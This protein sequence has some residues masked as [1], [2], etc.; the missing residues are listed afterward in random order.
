MDFISTSGSDKAP[1]GG[2]RLKAL[3]GVAVC[4][5]VWGDLALKCLTWKIFYVLFNWNVSFC[6]CFLLLHY[7]KKHFKAF[8][9][10]RSREGLTK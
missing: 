5:L 1:S 8:S 2:D 6:W 10:Y 3:V 7:A 9:F 4:V